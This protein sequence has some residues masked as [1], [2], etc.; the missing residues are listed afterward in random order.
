MQ[1]NL[2]ERKEFNTSKIPLVRF[3]LLI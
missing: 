3:L 1:E 2:S